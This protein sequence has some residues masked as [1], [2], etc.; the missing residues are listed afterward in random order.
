MYIR[1]PSS[2]FPVETQSQDTLNRTNAHHSSGTLEM[3]SI[4]DVFGIS[5][6]PVQLNYEMAPSIYDLEPLTTVQECAIALYRCG[7]NV[8]PLP[9]G[10]KKPFSNMPLKR[11][12]KSRLHRCGSAALPC[13]H[14]S[15][16]PL[17]EDL[18]S[19]RANIAVM[20][21][22][23]SRNLVCIDCE[24]SVAYD[25]MGKE[26]DRRGIPYWTYTSHRG[27]GYLLR[28]VEGEVVNI[29]KG[30]NDIFEDVE[31]WG[32]SQ[33]VVL[34]PSVHPEGTV[35]RWRN[36]IYPGFDEGGTLYQTLPAIYIDE[37]RWL[38]VTLKK[39]RQFQAEPGEM[40]RLPSQYA[41]ISK[42]N[43]EVLANGAKKGERNRR[44]T[45]LAY[46]LAGCGLL[47]EEIEVDYL[48]AASI[49]TPP[50]PEAEAMS[51]LS[52]AYSKPRSPAR[53]SLRA[54]LSTSTFHRQLFDFSDKFDWKRTFGRKAR[55]R[56]NL[57]ME[58]IKRSNRDGS[59]SSSAV[60]L[61]GEGLNRK[62]QFVS[63]CI[64]DLIKVGLIRRSKSWRTSASGANEYVFG[65]AVVIPSIV[66]SVLPPCNSSVNDWRYEK[67]SKTDAWKDVFGKLGDVTEKVFCFLLAGSYKSRY[68]IAKAMNAPESSV[69]RAV[70]KL[71]E[72][73]LVKFS[74][75]EGL[76]YAEPVTE[77][78]LTELSLQ[79]QSNGRAMLQ[80]INHTLDRGIYL[81]RIMDKLVRENLI[82]MEKR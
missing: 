2:K 81:N 7:F 44:L 65:E 5:I 47:Y 79:L 17:F 3:R 49:C 11:L 19:G 13:R 42:R 80:R 67:L 6:Q 62:Y 75:S 27:G 61:L 18:F 25:H 33:Y 28:V 55:T 9:Y 66:D 22:K 15:T 31:I 29:P 30:N 12:Y 53:K 14:F 74:Q 59:I 50:Y 37:L 35:Y 77:G 36:D 57:F 48:R 69:N 8:L 24:T 51:V 21:G 63:L 1:Q 56:K 78:Q 23:T 82:R 72:I 52:S 70:K 46:D 20:C 10:S 40:F 34:P 32:N 58:L 43:R 76:Y 4:M 71:L 68:A 39:D 45:A 38:G 73:R 41:V 54:S 16:V 64:R 60:R 26:L